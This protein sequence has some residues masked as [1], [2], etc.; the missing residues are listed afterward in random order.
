MSGTPAAVTS[1]KTVVRAAGGVVWRTA[2]EDVEV[3]LVHREKYDDWTLPK[4][5]AGPGETDEDTALREVEEETGARCTLGI[6]LPTI[7]YVDHLGR[8][9]TVRYWAM[10]VDSQSPRPPDD[11]VDRV[12][13]L[14]V[15]DAR[16]AL[17][18]SRDLRVLDAFANGRS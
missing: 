3:L 11:E 6:E 14:A 13:W 2:G 7:Q 4:G 5:K 9:K 12:E 16:Q 18:Y 8:P 15:D 10:T 17:T 1:T